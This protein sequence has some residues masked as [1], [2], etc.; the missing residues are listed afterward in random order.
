MTEQDADE[1]DQCINCGE[2]FGAEIGWDDLPKGGSYVE[3]TW[4]PEDEPSF[5]VAN[6]RRYCSVECLKDDASELPDHAL[7]GGS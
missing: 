3:V 7:G 4:N 1:T 2:S 5:V 6:T